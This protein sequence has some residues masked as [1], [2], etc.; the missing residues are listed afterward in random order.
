MSNTRYDNKQSEF[1]FNKGV[2]F[3]KI[4]EKHKNGCSTCKTK[5]GKS[6]CKILKVNNH[7]ALLC[8]Y[9]SVISVPFERKF[10][11]YYRNLLQ[12]LGKCYCELLCNKKS[13]LC[14][15]RVVEIDNKLVEFR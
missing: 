9:R 3:M 1:Y 8:F 11:K 5:E 10:F 6:K 7:Q 4:F 12:N 15:S 2:S 13:L 14:Y